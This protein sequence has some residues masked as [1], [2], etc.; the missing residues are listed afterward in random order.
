MFESTKAH[1]LFPTFC[2]QHD[3]PATEA[4]RLNRKLDA[5][6]EA[7]LTPRPA[8]PPGHTFQTSQD[9][10][11]RPQF[12][13][14]VQLIHLAGSGVISFLKLVH[15]AFEITG[16]WANIN[17]PGAPHAIHAHP[18]NLL[19]GVYYVKAGSGAEQIT[20]YD[21]RPQARVIAPKHSE[22]TIANSSQSMIDVKPGRM[23]IFPA[24]LEHSVPVNQSGQERMSI[25]FD[26]M[27]SDFTR[28]VSPPKWKGLG[29]NE[30]S[31]I[32][33]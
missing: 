15:Q 29:V 4:E 31:E 2:W 19:S 7:L 33:S 25:S 9:L 5:A 1:T 21:P 13:E 32:K 6:V 8:L 30:R 23:I 22:G 11:Q 26:L 17:P 20:F 14:L 10:H 3:L 27:P 24:W 12:A 28:M 16:C 18:N